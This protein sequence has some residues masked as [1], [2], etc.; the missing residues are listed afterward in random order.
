MRVEFHVQHATRRVEFGDV[1]DH[2]EHQAKI[3]LGVGEQHGPQLLAQDGRPVEA[4]ADARHPMAG[5]S[6][7]ERPIGRTLSPPTSMVR[8]ITGFPAAC[9]RTSP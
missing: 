2:R 9:S 4:D 8:K 5:L 3:A 6:P 1:G 7:G